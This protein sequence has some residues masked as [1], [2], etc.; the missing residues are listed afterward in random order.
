M[1]AY[2]S[3]PQVFSLGLVPPRTP[4][5]AD[6]QVPV[7]GSLGPARH[8]RCSHVYFRSRQ[9][10]A[11]VAYGFLD[12]EVSLQAR[13]DGSFWFELYCV[14]DGFQSATGSGREHPLRFEIQA[15]ERKL[16]A[17]EWQYPQIACGQLDPLVFSA[18]V[19]LTPQTYELADRV[20]IPSVEAIAQSCTATHSFVASRHADHT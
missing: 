4:E 20:F 1:H 16:A 12:I 15:G 5:R 11:D 3:E 10:P 19:A 13:R 8:G 6:A 9:E 14:G 18:S 2:V 17:V 7:D